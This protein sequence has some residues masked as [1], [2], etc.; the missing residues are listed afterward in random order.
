[1]HCHR[2]SA[3]LA[4][5]LTMEDALAGG[6]NKIM[7]GPFGD[8]AYR[9]SGWEKWQVVNRLSDG[10]NIVVH[11]MKNTITGAAEQFKFK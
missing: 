9:V 7:D 11:Y 4:E 8:P 2:K 10:T 5:E 1:V 6:G 3:N